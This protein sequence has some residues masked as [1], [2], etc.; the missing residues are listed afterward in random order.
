MA[1]GVGEASRNTFPSTGASCNTSY[2]NP[3][4]ATYANAL[5]KIDLGGVQSFNKLKFDISEMEDGVHRE[6]MARMREVQFGTSLT[7]LNNFNY[8]RF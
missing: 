7:S 4:H 2:S 8:Q 3:G 6:K 1:F 5:V